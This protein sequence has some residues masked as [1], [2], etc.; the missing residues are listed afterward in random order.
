VH[1]WYPRTFGFEVPPLQST[2]DGVATF[3]ETATCV[4]VRLLGDDTI[5]VVAPYGLDDLFDG[6]IRHNPTRVSAAF[7]E[8]RVGEKRW[9]TRWPKLR[10][11]AARLP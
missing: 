10:Y 5:H 8:R 11:V 1:V 2:A 9:T 6:V 7:Y 3:P 4:G